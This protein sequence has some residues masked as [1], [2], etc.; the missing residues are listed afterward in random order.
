MVVRFFNKA[1]D[2]DK[3]AGSSVIGDFLRF[4]SFFYSPA[5]ILM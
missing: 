4:V 5:H 2:A 1:H 3:G